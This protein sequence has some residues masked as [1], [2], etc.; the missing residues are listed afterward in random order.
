M[1]KFGLRSHIFSAYA[2][3]SALPHKVDLTQPPPWRLYQK[4]NSEID[5]DFL[6]MLFLLF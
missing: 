5:I 6:E 2:K 3:I 4:E 1:A